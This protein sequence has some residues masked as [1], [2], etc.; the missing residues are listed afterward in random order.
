MRRLPILLLAAL[1]F[2]GCSTGGPTRSEDGARLGD[3]AAAQ[4]T[5]IIEQARATAIVLQAQATAEA[6]IRQATGSMA[7]SVALDTPGP[8]TAPAVATSTPEADQPFLTTPVSPASEA[9]QVL[10]VQIAVDGAMVIVNF[11][12]PVS[13]A[14]SWAQGSVFVVDEAT[15]DVYANI[16]TLPSVGPLFGRPK[17]DGQVGY[18]MLANVPGLGPGAVVTV[19][20][21]EFKKEHVV[22]SW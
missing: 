20:L 1:A 12:A 3:E 6:M 4:A 10:S 5:A 14:R 16:P 18:V 2:V 9:I 17:E 8:T 22:V 21:G 15:G 13:V 19:V 7:T 11:K